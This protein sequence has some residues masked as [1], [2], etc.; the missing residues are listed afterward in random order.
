MFELALDTRAGLLK[1]DAEARRA[2]KT[3]VRILRYCS[4][5]DVEKLEYMAAPIEKAE[6]LSLGMELKT[7]L[8]H[9]Q[10]MIVIGP[11]ISKQ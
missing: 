10:T 1:A 6:L 5:K 7:D 11:N 2:I 3:E 9:Q 4:G 8:W